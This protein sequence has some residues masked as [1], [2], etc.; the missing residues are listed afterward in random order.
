MNWG[1]LYKAF[2]STTEFEIER[3]P[4][5]V[6]YQE[7]TGARE[8][9]GY[10]G[11]TGFVILEGNLLRPRGKASDTVTVFM[12]PTTSLLH[13]PMP[14]ALV[15]VGVHV[16]CCD[17]RYPRNDAPLIM[18]KVAVDLG[19]WIR[20]AREVLHYKKV[21]L[22][23]WSGGGS[24]SLFYQA[25][26]EHPTITHTPAGDPADL[27][28]AKLI[29]ADA[30]M[31]IAAHWSRAHTLSEWIDPSVT[32]ELNP[33]QREIELDL[34]DP[35]NPNQP[36]YSAD[37]VKR[38]R[39]AQLARQRKITGWVKQRLADIKAGKVTENERAFVV[40]RTMADPRWLDTTIEP[41][42]RK[43]NWCFIGE[44][45]AANTSAIGLGRFNT[46]RGW[47]SQ[48]SEDSRADGPKSAARISVP[49]MLIENSADDACAPS[50]A[51]A[52]FESNRYPGKE[53]HVIKGATHYY[54]NQ[55]EKLAEAAAICTD[56]LK[57]KG[58]LSA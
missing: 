49:Y 37:Y 32:D 34:Y 15:Q 19:A 2:M 3:I 11:A 36:P 58:F 17:S 6:R 5:T 52:L 46:L 43:A 22:C 50:H 7:T 26:A 53:K 54:L 45:K 20:H 44:P 56:W 23:G 33:D 38:F 4:L 21:V 41:S 27:K 48:W 16:L 55:P 24:L 57:R 10:Q 29:P 30:M 31:V 8:V 40:H 25:E 1:R 39:S 12:H 51:T 9:Y 47:L 35:R 14:N 13:L 18:E 42:D 28:A